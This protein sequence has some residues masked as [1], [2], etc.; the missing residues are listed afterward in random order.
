[1]TSASVHTR[2]ATQLAHIVGFSMTTKPEQAMKFYGETLGFRF[3]KD[4]GF[5]LVFDAHGTLLRVGKMKEFTPVPYT[6]LGWEVE[7]IPAVVSDLSTR[8]VVFERYKGMP[9]DEQ[10]IC[11]FPNGDRVAWFKDPEGNVLSLSE[12]KSVK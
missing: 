10:A 8:G 2:P 1:M 12:H 5:A 7:D 11:T 4:D 3:I 6:T 9:Q